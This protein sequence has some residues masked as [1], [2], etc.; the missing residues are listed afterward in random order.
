MRIVPRDPWRNRIAR[1]DR[2]PLPDDAD[3]V[4]QPVGHRDSAAQG[5]PFLAICAERVRLIADLLLHVEE[6]ISDLGID[7][8]IEPDA[9]FCILVPQLAVLAHEDRRYVPKL[10]LEIRFAPL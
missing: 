8:A 2:L 6:R 9:S 1:A 4:F 3:L 10:I 7:A 5:Y